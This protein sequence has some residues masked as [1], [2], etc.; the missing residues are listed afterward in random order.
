MGLY[1]Q[2][3]LSSLLLNFLPDL[4]T[5]FLL[6]PTVP[7]PVFFFTLAFTFFS[8]FLPH[9]CRFPTSKKNWLLC[10]LSGQLTFYFYFF[11]T[12]K[13]PFFVRTVVQNWQKLTTIPKM[14]TST[15]SP[16]RETTKKWQPLTFIA[17]ALTVVSNSLWRMACPH[18]IDLSPPK[19]I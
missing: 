11:S 8:L 18:L 10:R 19:L 9:Y 14:V 15:P 6:Y 17:G 12:Q 16:K 1:Y 5:A 4:P 7:H 2:A 13:S 3:I